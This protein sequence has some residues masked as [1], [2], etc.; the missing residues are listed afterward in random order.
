M[1]STKI[2]GCLKSILKTK[3]LQR[4]ELCQKDRTASGSIRVLV[5]KKKFLKLQRSDVCVGSVT[6]R[7]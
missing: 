3:N 1:Q 2:I 7:E 4:I 6:V 5:K